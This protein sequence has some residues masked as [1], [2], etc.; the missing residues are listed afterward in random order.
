MAMKLLL[1]KPTLGTYAHKPINLAL[2]SAIA[3]RRGW[4]TRLFD[5]GITDVSDQAGQPEQ[6]GKRFPAEGLAGKRAERMRSAVREFLQEFS[7]D[8]VA[9]T[10]ISDN[11]FTAAAITGTIRE[12]DPRIPVLWGGVEP[13]INPQRALREYRA[14]LV[15]R[16]EGIGAFDDVLRAYADNRDIRSIPNIWSWGEEGIIQNPVRPLEKDLDNLPFLDL[17][18]YPE[19][20]RQDRKHGE[21][22]RNADH[23]ITWGCPNSCSY[24][25]NDF[26]HALYGTGYFIRH[27]SAGRI[28]AELKWLKEQ[29][30]ITFFNFHDEDFLLKNEEYLET[31][32]SAYRQQVDL[33]FS[34]MASPGS[35]TER[36]AGLLK[37]M[38]CINVAFGVETGD[39]AIRTGILRRK[40]SREDIIRS[41]TLFNRAGIRTSS[42]NM[43]GLPFYSRECFE[44]TIELNRKA[45][46]GAPY[47][48]F[49]YPYE[50][51]A[52]RKTSIEGGFFDPENPDTAVNVITKPAL[53][54]SAITR[55]DLIGM[56]DVFSLYCRL[57]AGYY[58]YILRAEKQDRTGILLRDLLYRILCRMVSYRS[59]PL[60]KPGRRN[61][62]SDST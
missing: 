24:C 28:I 40:D 7:P 13:T 1:V 59:Y 57:P 54:F 36:K 4:E 55:E 20:S 30:G 33:P 6:D 22:Y 17:G 56:R 53:H 8:F 10:V 5:A 37:R 42:F 19:F 58:P 15:C 50:G 18:I 26:Y 11:R 27:Y 16:G 41:V 35:V 43:L 32:S 9:M 34:I 48:G 51:T 14:D 44:K 61:D 3:K 62:L 49:F 45:G 38:N 21:A 2:L 60:G 46:V 47:A 39:M 25:I 23:M 29:F 31:L 52:V 12:S